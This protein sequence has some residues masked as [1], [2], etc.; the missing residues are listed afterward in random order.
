MRSSLYAI[1]AAKRTV[2]GDLTP[3][4]SPSVLV[5]EE[6]CPVQ[7]DGVYRWALAKLAERHQDLHKTIELAE[8]FLQFSYRPFLE[9]LSYRRHAGH[10]NTES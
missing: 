8:L 2:S 7:V 6:N 9:N 3:S 1:Q 5:A 10:N 4:P